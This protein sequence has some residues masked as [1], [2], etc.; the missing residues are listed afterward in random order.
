MS[1]AKLQSVDRPRRW[2]LP[3]VLALLVLLVVIGALVS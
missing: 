1:G 2:L 3:T